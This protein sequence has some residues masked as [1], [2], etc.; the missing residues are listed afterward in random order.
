M[1]SNAENNHRALLSI[2]I[3][4]E[5]QRKIEVTA[6]DRGLSIRDYVVAVLQSAVDA[7]EHDDTIAAHAAWSQISAHSFAR[8][9]H[10]DEDQ[11]YDRLA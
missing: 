5:L 11:A 9:W 7:E 2:D 1:F 4:A 3:E 6:A 10:S 8:D